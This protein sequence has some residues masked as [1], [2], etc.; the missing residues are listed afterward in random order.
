MARYLG[1]WQTMAIFTEQFKG[2]LESP[3]RNLLLTLTLKPT[4]EEGL[5]VVKELSPQFDGNIA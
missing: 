1:R 3:L 5:Q 4:P 2:Q